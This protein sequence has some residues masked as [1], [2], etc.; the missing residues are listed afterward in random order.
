[1]HPQ[2]AAI[3]ATPAV[4][5][6]LDEAI[7][8]SIIDV[9]H[10][11]QAALDSQVVD[12]HNMMVSIGLS[13]NGLITN[14]NILNELGIPLSR[15]Q[16]LTYTSY[17]ALLIEIAR[18]AGGKYWSAAD[19]S[20]DP[21]TQTPITMFFRSR[22]KDLFTK[23]GKVG[24]GKEELSAWLGYHQRLRQAGAIPPA[25][26]S[27]EEAAK[28][29]EQ[30]IYITGKQV[31]Y[32]Q[33]CNR[34]KV[35]QDI[36]PNND[37]TIVRGPTNN[38]KGGE[39]FETA[40]IGIYAKTRFPKEAAA[41]INYFVNNPRSLELYLGENGFPASLVMNEHIRPF[42]GK[43]DGLASVFMDDV[44]KSFGGQIAP[45]ILAPSNSL[46][47]VRILLN[48]SEAVAFGQKTIE[49]AVDDFFTAAEKL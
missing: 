24:F 20:V 34:L 22:G 12:G 16:N 49:R 23:D 30:T 31:F 43:S 11:S 46:D 8:K 47:Y 2:Y 13:T 36:M 45:R 28:T 42:L 17:E 18:K 7:P 14:T 1:M 41:F 32:Y 3:F 40:N 9:S 48:E 5:L 29:Y 39:I 35:F 44:T 37:L 15:L 21:Q 26:I 19:D 25:Q 38:G 33:S 10:F 6:S 4:F 27:A